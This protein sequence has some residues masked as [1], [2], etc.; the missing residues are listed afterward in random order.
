M[1][2]TQNEAV[3][4]W[5]DRNIESAAWTDWRARSEVTMKSEGET[6]VLTWTEW[7]A[8]SVETERRHVFHGTLM[9]LTEQIS[10]IR[11]GG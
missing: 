5:L 7:D 11:A 3:S 2:T 9:E 8:T 4:I 1:S 10:D 6:V